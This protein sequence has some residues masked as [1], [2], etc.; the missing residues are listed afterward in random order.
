MQF[1]WNVR[2]Q[3][4]Q[5]MVIMQSVRVP[6]HTLTVI[7]TL[8][9]SVIITGDISSAKLLGRIAMDNR[10]KPTSLNIFD[11]K[12]ASYIVTQLCY[13]VT[14]LWRVICDRLQRRCAPLRLVLMFLLNPCL[15]LIQTRI[16]GFIFALITNTA[17]AIYWHS[18]MANRSQQLKP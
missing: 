5:H 15:K 1:I 13:I 4:L 10:R 18:Q 14:Q 12:S 9:L 7:A 8:Y 3:L 6:P 17:I 2:V 16:I 11:I